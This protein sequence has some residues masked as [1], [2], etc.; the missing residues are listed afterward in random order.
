METI[1]F[2]HMYYHKGKWQTKISIFS[3]YHWNHSYFIDHM[4]ILKLIPL[5]MY[6]SRSFNRFLSYPF[7]VM[8]PTKHENNGKTFVN[9]IK[10]EGASNFHHSETR[11]EL[12]TIRKSLYSF[13]Q[14]KWQRMFILWGK[15]IRNTAVQSWF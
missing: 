10:T 1:Q 8:S 7:C 12:N 6:G 11:I 2:S 9:T 14:R 15:K 4:N 5:F 13:L 3:F